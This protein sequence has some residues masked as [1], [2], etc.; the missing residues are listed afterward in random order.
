MIQ[1]ILQVVI[2]VGGDDLANTS[3]LQWLVV[4][5]SLIMAAK[6]PAEAFVADRAAK[7][8]K[9]DISVSTPY[10]EKGFKEKLLIS[11][12]Q[13]PFYII[14]TTFRVLSISIA[15]VALQWICCLIYPVLFLTII[16]IGYKKTSNGKDFLTRG[17]ISTLTTVDH[18]FGAERLFQIYWL[19]VNLVII[20][21]CGL[22]HGT[23]FIFPREHRYNLVFISTSIAGIC[24]GILSFALFFLSRTREEKEAH[25]VPDQEARAMNPQQMLFEKALE[26]IGQGNV[27]QSEFRRDFSGLYVCL[28]LPFSIWNSF[29]IAVIQGDPIWGVVGLLIDFLPGLEWHSR[30]DLVGP[31]NRL[32]WFLSSLFYPGFVFWSRVVGVFRGGGNSFHNLMI[33]MNGPRVIWGRLP[34][35]ALNLFIIFKQTNSLDDLLYEGHKESDLSDIE[36]ASSWSSLVMSLFGK[37]F[38][39]SRVS[40]MVAEQ[41]VL[42]RQT[43]AGGSDDEEQFVNWTFRRKARE[44]VKLFPLALACS[45]FRVFS[46]ALLTCCLRYYAIPLYILLVLGSVVLGRVRNPTNDSF[47]IRGMKSVLTIVDENYDDETPFQLY[48]FGCNCTLTLLLTFFVKMKGISLRGVNLFA[49]LGLENLSIVQN[50]TTFNVIILTIFATG[51]LSQILFFVMK[52]LKCAMPTIQ[53]EAIELERKDS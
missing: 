20:V 44:Q 38:A 51:V 49:A 22:V 6:G 30:K 25:P 53:E 17:L 5:K 46:F 37:I 9:N 41:I 19:A 15:V 39:F 42:P 18:R 43:R 26:D 33:Q 45:V 29:K 47:V 4:F 8:Q 2:I 1:L 36:I 10:H 24:S 48:W 34:S 7:R 28:D 35:L 27:Q 40:W 32:N 23:D 11:V 13:M 12:W 50:Q 3:W 16:I 31:Q 21:L 14:L 52:R